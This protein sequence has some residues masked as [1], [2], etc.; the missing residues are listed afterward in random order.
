MLKS[1][2]QEIA[3]MEQAIDPSTEDRHRIPADYFDMA[4]GTSTGG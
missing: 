2:M 1:L 3:T 4:G